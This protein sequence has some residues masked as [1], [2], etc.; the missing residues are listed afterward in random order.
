M[1]IAIK[2]KHL[3]TLLIAFC[4]F[5]TTFSANCTS[6]IQDYIKYLR[7]PEPGYS[8]YATFIMSSMKAPAKYVGFSTG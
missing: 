6:L 3:L 1:T 2:Q 7:T 4:V 5:Q 8:R